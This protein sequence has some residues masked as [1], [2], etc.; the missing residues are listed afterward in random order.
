MSEFVIRELSIVDW[1][2]YKTVRLNSLKDSP[3]SFGSTYDRE[4]SFSDADWQS[5]LVPQPGTNSTIPLVA[6]TGGKPVGLASGVVWD[7][8]TNVAHV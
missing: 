3:D 6:E 5:R 2:T 8:D 1:K 7:S 4:M